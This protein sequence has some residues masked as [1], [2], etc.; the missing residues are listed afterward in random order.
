MPVPTPADVRPRTVRRDLRGEPFMEWCSEQIE[1]SYPELPPLLEQLDRRLAPE[2]AD[3]VSDEGVDEVRYWVDPGTSTADL[4]RAW[5]RYIGQHPIADRSMPLVAVFLREMRMCR[6]IGTIAAFM[7]SHEGEVGEMITRLRHDVALSLVRNAYTIR[8][9]LGVK[10][11]RNCAL[12]RAYIESV[13][14]EANANETRRIRRDYGKLAVISS[15][16]GN[17]SAAEL[18]QARQHLYAVLDDEH[19]V[20]VASYLMESAIEEYHI[21]GD[22]AVIVETFRWGKRFR[23]PEDEWSNWWLVSGELMLHLAE[24]TSSAEVRSLI[25]AEA[26]ERLQRAQQVGNLELTHEVRS[27]LLRAMVSFLRE[28]PHVLDRKSLRGLRLPFGLRNRSPLPEILM[29]ASEHLA[30]ALRAGAERGQYIYRDALAGILTRTARA[31]TDAATVERL[32]RD[33]VRLRGPLAGKQ[34][35][36]DLRSRLDQAADR[37]L[38]A[39]VSRDDRERAAGLRELVALTDEFPDSPDAL[40]AI[41]NEIQKGGP[42]VVAVSKSSKDLTDAVSRGDYR[43]ILQ[44][45]AKVAIASS[46]F[47]RRALG[48]RGTTATLED[49]KSI[50]GQVFIIKRMTTDCYKR[51]ERRTAYTQE[52]LA[53]RSLLSDFGVVEHVLAVPLPAEAGQPESVLSV[54]RFEQGETLR[55][56]LGPYAYVHAEGGSAS[57]CVESLEPAVNFLALFHSSPLTEPGPLNARRTIKVRE[58]GRW[59]KQL[60]IDRDRAYD[61]WWKIVAHL[62][63]VPRRDAHTQN[64]VVLADRRLLAVDLESNGERPLGYELAQL[65]DDEPV[66]DPS[67]TDSR[68]RL[69]D[70]YI[71]AIRSA[72]TMVSWDDLRLGFEA[73]QAA[74]AVNLLT[75]G[76]R[77]HR[78]VRH[79][80][81]LLG[82]VART[83]N[84]AELRDW[85]ER[86]LRAWEIKAGR[87]SP[88]TLAQFTEGTRRRISKAMA[89][90]LR[91][92]PTAPLDRDGWIYADDLSSLLRASGMRIEPST[93]LAVAGALGESRFEL[94]RDSNEIRAVY[95]HSLRLHTMPSGTVP[96][97]I[98]WHGTALENLDGIFA[99]RSGLLPGRRRHVHLST[100]IG[101]AR[102]VARRHSDQTVVLQ[103]DARAVDGIFSPGEGI[104]LAPTVPAA[105]VSVPSIWMLA[106]SAGLLQDVS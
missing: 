10:L 68:M 46:D 93:L 50:S 36:R 18:Q 80:I 45:A 24:A 38:L 76:R 53:T 58:L 54:R 60:P 67:D 71:D 16:F 4:V 88:D 39:E 15:R 48:G 20:S 90:H 97:T 61:D 6:E 28:N 96:P 74:R 104:W 49:P 72:G 59:L 52:L 69:I 85:C 101:Q 23:V 94:S 7:H 3:W 95:G 77:D 89:F 66:L 65:I 30:A 86:I 75:D 17:A 103:I 47:R 22:P 34:P 37:L 64:W 100:D 82:L 9:H 70:Q 11:S 21:G 12:G 102:H 83:S 87:A 99:A 2:I 43:E 1:Q 84:S 105:A 79:A 106:E 42:A 91:H 63:T 41:A 51:D 27:K 33:A 73:G 92:N 55:E 26:D 8:F 98:L 25:L 40:V 5:R 81:A 32:L 13:L 62:P 78:A 31:S 14:T 19:D 29:E 57:K 35:L 44:R 56:S